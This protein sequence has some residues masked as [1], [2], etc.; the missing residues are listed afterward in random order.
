[1]DEMYEMAI[2]E[3]HSKL[4]GADCVGAPTENS[5]ESETHSGSATTCEKAMHC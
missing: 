3:D 1:M 2:Q 5:R 4:K